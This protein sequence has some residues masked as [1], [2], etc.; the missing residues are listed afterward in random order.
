MQKTLGEVALGRLKQ[1]ECG[2]SPLE[3]QKVGE[4]SREKDGLRQVPALF[5]RFTAIAFQ[6][7]KTNVLRYLV[8][9]GRRMAEETALVEKADATVLQEPGER[10]KRSGSGAFDRSESLDETIFNETILDSCPHLQ[11]NC[12]NSTGGL[13][14]FAGLRMGSR[15]RELSVAGTHTLNTCTRH[16]TAL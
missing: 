4:S 12:L 13:A 9:V 14:I 10:E 16:R 3:S 5:L 1:R 11:K 7:V 8:R 2:D 6:K 15:R